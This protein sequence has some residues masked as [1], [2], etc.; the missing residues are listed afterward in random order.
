MKKTLA[1]VL[2][3]DNIINQQEL[4]D[5]IKAHKK[6]QMPLTQVIQKK[7]YAGEVDILK[8]LSKLHGI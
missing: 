5:S 4:A 1:D 7:G 8:S 3:E 6:S 2:L